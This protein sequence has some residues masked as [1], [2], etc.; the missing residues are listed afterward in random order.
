MSWARK[1]RVP[2]GAREWPAY[3]R[4]ERVEYVISMYDHGYAGTMHDEEAREMLFSSLPYPNGEQAAYDFGLNDSGKGELSI[5]YIYTYKHWPKCWPAPGQTTGDCVSRAGANIGLIL[6]GVEAELGQPDPIT[7]KIEG[8]PEVSAE[9][10]TNGVIATEN[11]YGARGHSGQGASC[12]RLINYVIREGGIMLRQ[13]YPDLG[14]DFTKYNADIGD[15][16]GSSGT[17]AAVN[18]IAKQH[19]IRTS[20]NV[21]SEDVARDFIANG[22]PL[23]ACSDLGFSNK[24]DENGFSERSGSWGHSWVVMGYDDRKEIK[25][26]YGEPLC[27]FRHEWGRWNTGGRRILGTDIDIP[28]GSFWFR[29]SLLKKADLYAM[30]SIDGWPR[31]QLPDWSSGWN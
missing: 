9:A 13:N 17:P 18:T 7:N 20:T 19:Q 10:E 6:I 22:Y 11:I 3:S 30:S 23:W 12:D 5:P 8:F 16:W 4:N 27:L 25:D 1:P 29:A 31:R 2:K 24:R 21:E 26:K 15:R 28:E 14:V